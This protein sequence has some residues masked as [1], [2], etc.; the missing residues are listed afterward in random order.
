MYIFW[1][2]TSSWAQICPPRSEAI[3]SSPAAN[4]NVHLQCNSYEEWPLAFIQHTIID[5]HFLLYKHLQW[6]YKT[7]CVRNYKVCTAI[8]LYFYNGKYVACFAN[9]R[10]GYLLSHLFPRRL[11]AIIPST[12][13]RS[14]IVKMMW[15]VPLEGQNHC[16]IGGRLSSLRAKKWSP[17]DGVGIF[18]LS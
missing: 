14:V 13:H 5:L 15:S 6:M 10:H 18:E 16:N 12:I 8:C 11:H 3:I 2:L 17:W 9:N 7:L 1:I 4:S